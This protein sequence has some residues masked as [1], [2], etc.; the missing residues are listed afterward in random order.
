MASWHMA[1][2]A[3]IDKQ[4]DESLTEV[5]KD[6]LFRKYIQKG[7]DI[8]EQGVKVNPEDWRF[9]NLKAKLESNRYRNPDYASAIETYSELL[10]LP[11]L[12]DRIRES[13][14][15][16]IQHCMQH[17]PNLHQEAYDHAVKLFQSGEGYHVPTVL[18]EIL[19]GQNHPLNIVSERLSLSE[20]Y[21]SDKKAY[22]V[23]KIKW[24]NRDLGQKPY[25]LEESIRELESKLQIAQSN[26]LFPH[27]PL[28]MK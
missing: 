6:Q 23:L 3:A 11:D 15:I 28:F 5:G 13:T 24:K 12:P 16:K 4:V 27:K 17:L 25:G 21:G 8:L 18:N 1:S 14:G 22:H 2:N 20:I 26:R 9:L 7:K 10:K 19:I